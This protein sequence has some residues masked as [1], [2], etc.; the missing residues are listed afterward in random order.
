MGTARTQG[1]HGVGR[2]RPGP[3]GLIPPMVGP[4][5][6]PQLR[7]AAKRIRRPPGL[8]GYLGRLGEMGHLRRL[9]G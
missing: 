8:P 5:Q 1:T 4:S 3:Y 7:L 2:Q 9:G 6:K